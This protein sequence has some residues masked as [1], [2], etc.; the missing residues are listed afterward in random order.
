MS[1]KFIKVSVL[2]FVVGI[3]IGLYMGVTGQFGFTSAHAHVNLL[4][5]LSQ[6][7]IGLIYHTFPRTNNNKLAVVHFWAF[8][9][10]IPT[11]VLG[12]IFIGAEQYPV[13]SLIAE[14]GGMFIVIGLIS[15]VWNIFSN[16]R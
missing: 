13:G 6:A 16:I 11:M 10:G 4:G 2:Y 1:E 9:I 14:V 3:S 5:W 12:L 8:N 15:F 7:V